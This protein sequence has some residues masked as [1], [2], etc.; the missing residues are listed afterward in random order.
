LSQRTRARTTGAEPKRTRTQRVT[1]QPQSVASVAPEPAPSTPSSLAPEELARALRAVATE[2]ERDPALA[3][4]V[5]AA[6]SPEPAANP[7]TRPQAAVAE[8]EQAP[9]RLGG[10]KTFRPRIITGAAPELG[11]GI[12]DPFALRVRLGERGLRAALDELRLGTLR[13]IV[14]EHKL[15]PKGRLKGLN[16][17]QKLR[18]LILAATAATA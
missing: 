12:P 1:A 11:M 15:D 7:D 5:A 6:M 2:L 4:R 16:D 17:E 18:E 10:G 14:R 8:D 13:A 3:A 9:P